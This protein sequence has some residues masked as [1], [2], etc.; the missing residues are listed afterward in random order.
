MLVDE[1][2]SCFDLE[3]LQY[4]CHDNHKWTV[5]FGVLYGTSLWQVGDSTEQNGTYK[6]H[7]VKVNHD[8]LTHW[9]EHMIGDMELLPTDAIPL[10][11]KDWVNSFDELESNK[12]AIS[13]RGWFP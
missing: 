12:K 7:P 9:I 5:V 3:F 1:H 11:N 8:I 2:G 6:I 10:I 13:E 4:I